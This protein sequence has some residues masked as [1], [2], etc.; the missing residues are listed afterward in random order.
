VTFLDSAANISK[1]LL[2]LRFSQIIDES[3]SLLGYDDVLLGKLSPMFQRNLMPPSSRSLTTTYILNM[4]TLGSSEMFATIY[5]L[6]HHIPE[7][8]NLH[9][10]KT[11]TIF[12]VM[13]NN[14]QGIMKC[15]LNLTTISQ[16]IQIFTTL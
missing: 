9:T 12:K 16:A 2:N 14:A 15:V 6:K 3:T 10:R 1:T 11:N 5:Q 13:I 7:D 8:L 4:E